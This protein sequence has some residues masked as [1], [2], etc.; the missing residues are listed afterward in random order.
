[1]RYGNATEATMATLTHRTEMQLAR[2]ELL[3]LDDIRGTRLRCLEGSVWITLHRD[4]RDIVLETGDSFTVDRGGVTLVHALAPARV[5][6][7][8]SY[9]T[10]AL[11]R[12]RGWSALGRLGRRLQA[13]LSSP[14]PAGA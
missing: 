5:S 10:A 8:N 1:M 3:A 11:A 12:P 6:V 7:E 4:P 9:D 2:E 13:A 14:I